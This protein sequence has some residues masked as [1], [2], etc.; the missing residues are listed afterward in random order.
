MIL[1]DP[2]GLR[3]GTELGQ[4]ASLGGEYLQRANEKR[5]KPCLR[6]RG[7]TLWQLPQSVMQHDDLRTLVGRCLAGDQSAMA[8]LVDGFQRQ[9]FALCLRMLCN[10]QDAED[11]T[12]ETML[13][14]LRNLD[15][16]DPNREFRPWLFAI[17][18][19]RCRTLLSARKKRP[20]RSLLVEDVADP[21]PPAEARGSIA[22]EIQFGLAE[23][24]EEYRLAFLLFH[25]QE[26]SYLE[27]AES[28]D[29]PVGTVKTW[30]H[31]ARSELARRLRRRMNE[32]TPHEVRRV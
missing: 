11:M 19:N 12:Q 8:D 23:L 5:L 3:I 2:G 26:M 10:R 9:V 20:V 15:R 30:I 21:G 1:G 4:E 24:R 28:M 27:I 31:R 18:G 14:A 6:P 7:S 25:E 32:E 13:R 22:E 16:W 29:C 17:A